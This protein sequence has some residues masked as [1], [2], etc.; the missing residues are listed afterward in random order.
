M[1]SRQGGNPPLRPLI[2]RSDPPGRD[3][4]ETRKSG[5]ERPDRTTA[6]VADAERRPRP[7]GR[8]TRNGSREKSPG[9]GIIIPQ[10]AR[11]SPGLLI[12]TD[13]EPGYSASEKTVSVTRTSAAVFVRLLK[14]LASPPRLDQSGQAPD[15]E[16]SASRVRTSR[17]S[18][19]TAGHGRDNRDDRDKN[20]GLPP[21]A[22]RHRHRSRAAPVVA[23]VVGKTPGPPDG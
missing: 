1:F 22:H 10:K 18:A 5:A 12:L 2:Q 14:F 7:A 9:C 3:G 8:S 16:D 21:P 23:F 19:R 11:H 6:T 15:R 4:R 20:G 13:S 17:F